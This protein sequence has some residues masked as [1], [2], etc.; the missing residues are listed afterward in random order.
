MYTKVKS[1]FIGKNGTTEEHLRRREGVS[2]LILGINVRKMI[3]RD[4]GGLEE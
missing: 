2:Y 4:Q 3:F 1:V